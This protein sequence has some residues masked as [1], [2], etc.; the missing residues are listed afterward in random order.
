MFSC[1]KQRLYW[2][3]VCVWHPIF[4]CSNGFQWAVKKGKHKDIFLLLCQASYTHYY[5]AKC[6]G[7]LVFSMWQCVCICPDL[8]KP[9]INKTFCLYVLLPGQSG[10]RRGLRLCGEDGVLDGH[11][12][13]LHQQ[14]QP[15][16]RR[17][18]F[19]CHNRWA[20]HRSPVSLEEGDTIF[21]ITTGELFTGL[22]SACRE[23]K[24]SLLSQ[25]L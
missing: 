16:R 4:W 1:C 9:L 7:W 17:H 22:M 15:G 25:Q 14:G 19:S 20:V 8:N 23:E 21:L 2:V 18:N 11:H 6:I 13:A 3:C 10:D 24:P 5:G 12:R